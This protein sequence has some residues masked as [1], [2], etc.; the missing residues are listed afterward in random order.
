VATV[1]GGLEVIHLFTGRPLC[2]LLLPS[3]KAASSDGA[4]ADVNRDQIIDQVLAVMDD[5]AQKLLQCKGVALAGVPPLD[6]LWNGSICTSFFELASFFAKATLPEQ[7]Y[8]TIAPSFLP[9]TTASGLDSIFIV[10]SGYVTSFSPNGK[11]LWALHTEATW[12]KNDYASLAAVYVLPT[13]PV[14][15]IITTGKSLVLISPLGSVL[16][17]QPLRKTSSALA[18]G[19]DEIRSIAPPAL[20]DFNND[21]ITDVVVLGHDGFYGYAIQKGTGSVLFPGLVL[22]LIGVMIYALIKGESR[23]DNS[24]KRALPK[25]RALD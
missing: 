6:Q 23:L 11:K 20:G 25:K 1:K 19:E 13:D 14:P 12:S 15:H 16:S 7:Q 17:T 18:E 8:F 3:L 5:P 22:S 9:S 2:R 24:N 4:F 21:G 10:S